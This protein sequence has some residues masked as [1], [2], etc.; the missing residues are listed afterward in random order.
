[1]NNIL[2]INNEIKKECLIMDKKSYY[3]QREINCL[4]KL[5]TVTPDVL[6]LDIN[7]PNMNGLDVLK[8]LKLKNGITIRKV[9]YM[10]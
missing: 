1:M 10:F 5:E 9:I 2:V 3:E 8:N 6:L 7:M 4:E